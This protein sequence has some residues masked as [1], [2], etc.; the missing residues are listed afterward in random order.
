MTT[1][2][3]SKS[4]DTI[5]TDMVKHVALLVRLGLTEEEAREFSHQFNAIIDYFHLLNEVDTASIPP[6]NAS[7]QA[8]NVLRA[9]QVAPS[10]SREEFL[11]NAPHAEGSF[12]R[13][14]GVFDED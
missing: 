14:P 9:D 7:T 4:T 6:A 12:V 3:E 13:V 1:Q 5:G 11:K 10:M 2:N 8:T